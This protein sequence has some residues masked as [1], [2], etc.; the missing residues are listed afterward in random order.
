MKQLYCLFIVLALFAGNLFAQQPAQ[1]SAENA[2]LSLEDCLNIGLERN[3][4]LRIV[5]NEEIIARNNATR[6]NAGQLPSIALNGGYSGNYFGNNYTL[7]NDSTSG[8]AASYNGTLNAAITAEWTLFNGFSIQS[9]YARLQELKAMGELNTRMALEDF[10]ANLSAEYYN[11]IKEQLSLANL[12]ASLEFSQDRLYIVEAS[13]GIGAASGLDYQ[14][15]QVDY[16]AD[17]SAYITQ[18]EVVAASRFKLNQLM[19]LDSIEAPLAL[20]DTTIA[21]DTCILR[22]SIWM[23]AQENNAQLLVAYKNHRLSQLDLKQA[24]SRNYPYLKLNGGYQWRDNSY[25]NSTYLR[26]TQMGPQFG[27]TAGITLFDGMNRR[28]EQQNARIQMENKQLQIEQFQLALK[29]DMANLWTA[30]TNN[31][32]LY[33]IERDNQVVAQINF[34]IAMERYRLRELSGIELREAQLSLLESEKRLLQAEYNIKLCEISLL[35]LS[36]QILDMLGE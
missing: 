12:K 35:H 24:Q 9:N 23:A 7:P 28:R 17:H 6:G 33:N 31:I 19:A 20:A 10:V 36:G 16:N 30:Y 11:Y 5:R 27:I 18:L 14:Q 29:T 13:Y 22:D 25:E 2:P 32:K 26:Q 8:T 1:Q 4:D 3:F 34:D 21:I 15:A